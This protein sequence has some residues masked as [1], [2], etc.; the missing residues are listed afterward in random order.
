M[1]PVLIAF[2]GVLVAAVATG[3][4]AG[5]YV[6]EPRPCLLVW[7]V[8]ALGLLVAL[9]AAGVGLA[10]VAGLIFATAALSTARFST[11]WPLAS[12][13]YGCGAHLVRGHKRSGDCG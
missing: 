9:A 3:P 8:A 12:Q 13:H 6:R 11:A 10:T 2:A 1:L 7:T 5:R 4:L